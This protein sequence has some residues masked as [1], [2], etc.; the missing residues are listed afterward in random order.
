MSAPL[1]GNALAGMLL[2]LLAGDADTGLGECA[3]CHTVLRIA[4]ARVY[5]SGPG[6]VARCPACDASLIRMVRSPDTTWLDV[7]GLAYLQFR[8]SAGA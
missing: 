7:R 8:E 5:P 2:D 6:T 3:G 4:E 1:D